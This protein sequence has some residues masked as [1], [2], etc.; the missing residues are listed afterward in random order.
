[1]STAFHPQTDGE[2]ERVNQELE[3]YLR[4]FCNY[5]VDNWAELI[6][7]MEFTHN[8]RVHSATGHSP[9]E[10]W[11]GYQPEFIPPLNFATTIPTVEER[12]ESMDR[13]WKEVTA[14]LKTAAETMKRTGLERPS[15][16]F[17]EG[18]LAWL[19][20]TNLHTTHPKAK[21]APR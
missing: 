6:P 12:L 4:I 21:L 9:F 7:F 18:D 16:I 13:I 19:E 11:Y 8:A 10:V 3:Q 5:Q 1:M 17:K 20:G 14:A 15:R 2:T